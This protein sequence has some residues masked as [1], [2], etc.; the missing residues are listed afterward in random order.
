MKRQDAQPGNANAYFD[1]ILNNTRQ[2]IADRGYDPLPIG[3]I[4][5]CTDCI[6]Q[7]LRSIKRTGDATLRQ[8]A[9]DIIIEIN[10]GFD[11][12]DGTC[13]CVKKF[14]FIRIRGK[15]HA[16][17]KDMALKATLRT[18]TNVR[19]RPV[20][21]DFAVTNDGEMVLNWEGKGIAGM[22]AETVFGL[23]RGKLTR[24]AQ[25]VLPGLIRKAIE[26]NLDKVADFTTP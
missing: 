1:E 26:N 21:E 18:S 13:N 25:R 5:I 7:G 11:Q 14:L 4:D 23:V 9:D 6:L 8:E 3:T 24:H 10:V 19:L 16:T 2:L 20:L 17:L 15:L 22:I 12:L